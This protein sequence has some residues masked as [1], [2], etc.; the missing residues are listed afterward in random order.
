M[1]FESGFKKRKSVNIADI[2]G[3]CIPEQGSGAAESSTSHGTEAGRGDREKDRGGGAK[4]AR[5]SDNVEEIRQ[6][7]RGKIVDGLEGVQK[8]FKINSVF[9]RKPVQ[10]LQ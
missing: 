7:R 2:R 3:E 4:G 5:G 10:M 6:I 9:Y 1:S 8:Y